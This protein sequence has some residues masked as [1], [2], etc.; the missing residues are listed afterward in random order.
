M[1]FHI[2]LIMIL[3]VW[4]RHCIFFLLMKL[5]FVRTTMRHQI[6]NSLKSLVRFLLDSFGKLRT[7]EIKPGNFVQFP[8]NFSLDLFVS[9]RTNELTLFCT[10]AVRSSAGS[11][12]FCRLIQ[13]MMNRRHLSSMFPVCNK[14]NQACKNIVLT[15][16]R[17]T[18][19]VERCNIEPFYQDDCGKRTDVSRL[20]NR[21]V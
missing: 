19:Q 7:V 20:R 1:H 12:G 17:K 2:G 3:R 5:L 13:I 15:P 16:Y 11:S 18:K 14:C 9:L 8:S 21:F 4:I 6:G 10:S